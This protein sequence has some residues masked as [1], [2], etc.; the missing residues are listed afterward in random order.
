MEK[1]YRKTIPFIIASR[2]IKCLRVNLTK[3]ADDFYKENYIHL[4]SLL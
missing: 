3:D 2:K 4:F 1:E